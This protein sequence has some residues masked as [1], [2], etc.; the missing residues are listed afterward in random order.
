[1]SD[2]VDA[3][4]TFRNEFGCGLVQAKAMWDRYG[5]LERMREAAR[6]AG[7]TEPDSVRADRLQRDLDALRADV[8]I[9]LRGFDEGVFVRE[10][11]HDAQSGW[12]VKMLPYIAAL[13]RIIAANPSPAE[14]IDK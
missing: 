9:V 10:V 13:G 4:R 7:I 12:A 2:C 5:S 14:G 1:M 11:A 8:R 3:V 6:T